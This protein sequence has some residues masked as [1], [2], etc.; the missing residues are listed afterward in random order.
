MRFEFLIRNER[1]AFVCRGRQHFYSQRVRNTNSFNYRKEQQWNINSDMEMS[2]FTS[3]YGRNWL[4][5]RGCSV[6]LV[7][8]FGVMWEWA[9]MKTGKPCTT[10]DSEKPNRWRWC[11]FK[12][13]AHCHVLSHTRLLAKQKCSFSAFCAFTQLGLFMRTA[14]G[15]YTFLGIPFYMYGCVCTSNIQEMK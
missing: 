14:H 12:S 6:K 1:K 15:S 7:Y 4:T 13:A 8:I 3:I 5:I 2:A 10:Y 11:S 9:Y